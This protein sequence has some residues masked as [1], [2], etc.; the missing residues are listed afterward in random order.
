MGRIVEKWFLEHVQLAAATHY[1]SIVFPDGPCRQHSIH[2]AGDGVIACTA[3]VQHC[4]FPHDPTKAIAAADRAINPAVV[5]ELRLWPQDIAVGT[6]TIAASTGAT[7]GARASWSNQL[8]KHSR[9]V[10]VV[11]VPGKLS[12]RGIGELFTP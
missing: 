7:G 8:A 1:Y 3:T 5:S 10:I 12:V 11:T 4:D 9:L 2:L 6:L